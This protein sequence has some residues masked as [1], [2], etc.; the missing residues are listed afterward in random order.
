MATINALLKL[1]Q[2]EEAKLEEELVEKEDPYPNPPLWWLLFRTTEYKRYKD[3]HNLY[4]SIVVADKKMIGIDEKI[5]K[6]EKEHAEMSIYIRDM[7]KKMADD[8]GLRMP[9][10]LPIG[11]TIQS[12]ISPALWKSALFTFSRNER[13]EKRM[14]LEHGKMRACLLAKSVIEDLLRGVD[15]AYDIDDL[16]EITKYLDDTGTVSNMKKLDAMATSLNSRMDSV[17]MGIAESQ[18]ADIVDIG[19]TPMSTNGNDIEARFAQLLLQHLA[20]ESIQMVP[21]TSPT[22]LVFPNQPTGAIDA[23]MAASM[24]IPQG[25]ENTQP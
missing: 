9:K 7:F 17:Q 14:N 22:S 10:P 1:R 15:D 3:R 19:T 23:R 12:I 4:G 21:Q 8:V 18:F 5:K 11:F 6:L 2:A 16:N 24:T 25:V 20:P 13:L